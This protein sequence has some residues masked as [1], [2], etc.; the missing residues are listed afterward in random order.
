[1]Q[2]VIDKHKE[3]IQWIERAKQEQETKNDKTIALHETKVNFLEEK[4]EDLKFQ[5]L[6]KDKQIEST[7]DQLSKKPTDT[8]Q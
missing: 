1:M 8:S 5:L 3:E 6:E 2:E 4:I 7:I